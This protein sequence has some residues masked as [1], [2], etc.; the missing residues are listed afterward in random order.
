M[1]KK[2]FIQLL[3]VQLECRYLNNSKGN[4]TLLQSNVRELIY[5]PLG[6]PQTF[7]FASHQLGLRRREVNARVHA[8]CECHSFPQQSVERCS[9]INFK[10]N[11]HQR[12]ALTRALYEIARRE[13]RYSACTHLIIFLA[14]SILRRFAVRRAGNCATWCCTRSSFVRTCA[15]SLSLTCTFHS[16]VRDGS[17]ATFLD[18]LWSSLRPTLTGEYMLLELV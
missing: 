9:T 3:N 5:S 11:F 1:F 13:M 14:L 10:N 15:R 6:R 12:V 8:P 2:I 4:N 18:L 16:S 17:S 7:A